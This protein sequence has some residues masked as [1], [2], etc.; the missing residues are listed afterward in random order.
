[1]KRPLCVTALLVCQMLFVSVDIASAQF[2]Q[3]KVVRFVVGAPPGGGYDLMTRVIV[4]NIGKHIPG[5]PTVIVENVPGAGS[6]IV[7]NQLFS[8][9]KND[10]LAI[11]LFNGGHIL[12]QVL[13]Q[14]GYEFDPQ[15]FIY[16]GAANKENSVFVFKKKSGI[17]S[18]DKWRA[19]S[20]PVKVGGLV[21]GNFLDNMD[22]LAKDIL[23]FPVHIVTGYKGL[24]EIF[25]A[26]ES[27]EVA[28]GP[29][30]W[31]T[32]KVGRKNLLESGDIV[33]V[34]QGT[35]KPL[36]EI[37]DVPRMID[38]AKTDEQKKIV[39]ISIHYAN[40]Y[41]RP[42]VVAPGTLKDRVDILR[43]AFQETLKDKEFLA[44]INKMN[45]TLD[46]TTAEGLTTAVANSAKLDQDM[47]AKLR[48]ILFK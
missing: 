33:P 41:S 11:G 38:F 4:R 29:S 15:K 13:G 42:Y 16:I 3:G 31:D 14:P 10:G 25:M 36:K 43:N 2:Y 22:R 40:D 34:L 30:G 7:A 32:V 37:P 44:E 47:K 17:T 6:L 9:T 26:M 24:A 18:T 39:E 8:A 21:R 35:A 48:D 12:N 27:G 19:S 5:N 23:G 46:P 1:M 28:G 45:F 20:V